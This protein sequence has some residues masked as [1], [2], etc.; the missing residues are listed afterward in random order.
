MKNSIRIAVTMETRARE[1]FEIALGL[2]KANLPDGSEVTVSYGFGNSGLGGL[3]APQCLVG[4]SFDLAFVNPSPITYMALNGIEPYKAK[5]EIRN[6]AV[7]PSWDK[8]G[9][10][11]K[12]GLG[13]KSLKEIGEKK[14]PLKLSTRGQGP[15]GTTDFTIGKILSFYG[16]SVENIPEWGGV[17]D[18]VP[19]PGHRRRLEG[20]QN[21]A[22]DAIFDEGIRN[23]MNAALAQDM[24][25]IPLEDAAFAHME[26]FGFPRAVIPKSIFQDLD[27]DIPALEFGGWPLFC[28]ADFPDELAYTIVDLDGPVPDETIDSLRNIEG[29]LALRNL[30]KPIS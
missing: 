26:R 20:I 3:D 21:N 4:K 29:V 27:D 17:L 25:L 1:A 30:G 2:S 5:I 14:I 7:F 9:F 8:I 10:A 18:R 23:W 19:T 11:V 16:W 28:R 22:Y 24:V 13:V 12:R 6:L 15:E